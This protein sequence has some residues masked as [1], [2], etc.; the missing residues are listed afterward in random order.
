VFGK[1]LLLFTVIPVVELYLLIAIGQWVGAGPTI[2]I[3][4]VTGFV[5]AWLAKR[6]GAR[7][8]RNWQESMARGEIPKEG[9]I[10][11][12]LVLLGG[13]LLVTPGVVSDVVGLGLLLPWTRRLVANVVRKRL[14]Q[15]LSVQGLMADPSVLM[16][17]GFMGGGAGMGGPGGTV[18][19]VEVVEA[20]PADEGEVPPER[21]R[22]V[23][24]A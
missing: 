13:V 23:S 16:G 22:D 6:E 15:R 8:L 19:D 3:V 1:L 5:G 18:I 17:A 14:E 4:L 21:Q 11:S 10:S 7:V 24:E 12:V 9:V 20:P 2:A